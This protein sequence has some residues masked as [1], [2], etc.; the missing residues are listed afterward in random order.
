MIVPSDNKKIAAF[1]SAY[2]KVGDKVLQ[3]TT[4]G[5][6][7]FVCLFCL[8]FRLNCVFLCAESLLKD[9]PDL[10]K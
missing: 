4:L 6:C 7:F 9:H 2:K 8:L 10:L 3:Y 1:T 5:T